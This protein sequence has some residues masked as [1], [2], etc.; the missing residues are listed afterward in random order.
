MGAL[1]A[2]KEEIDEPVRKARESIDRWQDRFGGAFS[3]FVRVGTSEETAQT[4]VVGDAVLANRIQ[5]QTRMPFGIE[6]A[7]A[8]FTERDRLRELAAECGDIMPT[9]AAI[10][11]QAIANIK[12][13][14]Q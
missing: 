8:L 3:G 5:T 9:S 6:R 13:A 1:D 7:S 12:E 2:W 4:R 10:T 11:Q 14:A